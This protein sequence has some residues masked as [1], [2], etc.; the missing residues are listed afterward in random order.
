MQYL[1]YAVGDEATGIPAPGIPAPG[2]PAPGIPAPVMGETSVFK[3]L[4]ATYQEDGH[5]T[6][7]IVQQIDSQ[8]VMYAEDLSDGSAR[9]V[10]ASGSFLF[11]RDELVDCVPPTLETDRMLN[12]LDLEVLASNAAAF[13]E[14]TISYEERPPLPR[15]ELTGDDCLRFNTKASNLSDPEF[16]MQHIGQVFGGD[17]FSDD[18]DAGVDMLLGGNT[19]RDVAARFPASSRGQRQAFHDAEA[20]ALMADPNNERNQHL[21]GMHQEF[22]ELLKV[23]LGLEEAEAVAIYRRHHPKSQLTVGYAVWLLKLKLKLLLSSKKPVAAA[24]AAAAFAFAAAAAAA[25]V[26]A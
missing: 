26:V 4:E 15:S 17:V 12:D 3:Y 20:R 24:F 5:G 13:E 18:G 14:V 11:R 9:L 22:R 2:I 8:T 7:L 21:V 25:V 10:S 1:R 6:L 19:R 23:R 16:Q